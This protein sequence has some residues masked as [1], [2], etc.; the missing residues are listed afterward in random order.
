MSLDLSEVD[1]RLSDRSV[2]LNGS[3]ASF[4][5]GI[6]RQVSDKDGGR[7]VSQH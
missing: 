6:E 2:I 4:M 3:D 7:V 1:S 5:M